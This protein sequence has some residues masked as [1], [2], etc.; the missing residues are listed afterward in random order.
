[1]LHEDKKVKRIDCQLS[2]K[3]ILCSLISDEQYYILNEDI[4]P[5]RKCIYIAN[6][7]HGQ[8]KRN[9]QALLS[10]QDGIIIDKKLQRL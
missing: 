4:N 7:N 3:L 9:C 8:C 1:M 2:M 6:K 10:D 5:P